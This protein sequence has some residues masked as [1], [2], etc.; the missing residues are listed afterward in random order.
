MQNETTTELIVIR[1]GQSAWNISNR[2]QGHIDTELSDEGRQ[3]AVKVA[4]HLAAEPIEAIYSSDLRRAMETAKPLAQKKGLPVQADTSLR[5]RN[6]GIFQGLTFRD[7]AEKFPQEYEKFMTWDPDYLIPEGESSRQKY[8][9][10]VACFQKIARENAGRTV[11]VFTHGGVIDA[12][13]RFIL[14]I[15][16]STP[17]RYKNYNAS[18]NRIIIDERGWFLGTWGEILHLRR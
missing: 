5:E 8:E 2:F 14:G 3:Q 16:L 9:R 13:L 17:R 6:M 4:E 11:A 1:H 7:I 18:I 10:T 12:L 15:P